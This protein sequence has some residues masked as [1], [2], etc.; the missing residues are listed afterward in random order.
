M[1]KVSVSRSELD[2]EMRGDYP[3]V[4]DAGIVKQLI[5]QDDRF[6][7]DIVQKRLDQI[8]DDYIDPYTPI[9]AP[10]NGVYIASKREVNYGYDVHT[11]DSVHPVDV[12]LRPSD[13]RFIAEAR[14]AVPEL[15]A[16]VRRLRALL[17]GAGN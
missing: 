2:A 16:E 8:I 1:P 6:L 17:D 12:Y 4:T 10:D 3:D 5:P 11:G 9:A 13:A 7:D 14:T 15:I